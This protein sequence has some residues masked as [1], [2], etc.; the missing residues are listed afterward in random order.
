MAVSRGQVEEVHDLLRK[1]ALH[2]HMKRRNEPESTFRTV[3]VEDVKAVQHILQHRPHVKPLQSR[4]QPSRLLPGRTC[5]KRVTFQDE[6]RDE[7]SDEPFEDGPVDGFWEGIV[8]PET[9]ERSSNPP[10]EE[11]EAPTIYISSADSSDGVTPSPMNTH[12]SVP[13]SPAGQIGHARHALPNVMSETSRRHHQLS[14]QVADQWRLVGKYTQ[15]AAHHK[16]KAV[17][18]EQEMKYL[19]EQ[20]NESSTYYM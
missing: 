18:L 12:Q 19:E 14:L 1:A 17:S 8:V 7:N 16:E 13:S 4:V 11:N 10:A 2:R 3:T 20:L 6:S 15:Q 5:K 9:P